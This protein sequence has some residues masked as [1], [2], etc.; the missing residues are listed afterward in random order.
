MLKRQLTPICVLNRMKLANAKKG[1]NDS[2]QP[3]QTKPLKVLDVT[4]EVE[5]VKND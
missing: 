2:G 4:C 3:N 1:L 5:R